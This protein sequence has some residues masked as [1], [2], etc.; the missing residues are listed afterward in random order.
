M[1]VNSTSSTPTAPST[2]LARRER[3]G[4]GMGGRIDTNGL[5]QLRMAVRARVTGGP[6]AA[7]RGETRPRTG[8]RLGAVVGGQE[9]GL[10]VVVPRPPHLQRDPADRA[11][12][13]VDV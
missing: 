3:V 5:L 8:Q 2:S 11:H 6:T 13:A 9:E 7:D 1:A 10:G 4:T 12:R